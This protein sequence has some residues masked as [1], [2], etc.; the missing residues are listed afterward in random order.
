[1]SSQ[2]SMT[3][4]KKN[5]GFFFYKSCIILGS[6]AFYWPYNWPFG[7][8]FGSIDAE[9]QVELE[10]TKKVHSPKIPKRPRV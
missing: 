6:L 9:F 8:I 5:Q 2:K 10:D 4:M 3:P 7:M 1:M